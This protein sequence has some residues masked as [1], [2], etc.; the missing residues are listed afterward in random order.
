M[1]HGTV[2]AT[3]E[4]TI[5]STRG[6]T[7]STRTNRIAMRTISRARTVAFSRAIFWRM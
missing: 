2:A 5:H 4:T 3:V 6:L 1:S 7:P